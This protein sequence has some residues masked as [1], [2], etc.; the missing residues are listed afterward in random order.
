M[1]TKTW[2]NKAR[3]RRMKIE[4]QGANYKSDRGDR[5]RKV[6]RGLSKRPTRAGRQLMKPLDIR[7]GRDSVH[8]CIKNIWHQASP[9]KHY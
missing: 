1:R 6:A 4:E 5:A 3:K 2:Q 7:F 8:D 9:K